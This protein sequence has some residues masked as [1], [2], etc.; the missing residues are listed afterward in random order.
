MDQ[1]SVD[2]IT[3]NGSV[4]PVSPVSPVSPIGPIGP[5]VPT[6]PQSSFEPPSPPE[7]GVSIDNST[8]LASSSLQNRPI[9]PSHHD[10][11]KVSLLDVV[12]T[13][14]HQLRFYYTAL[15]CVTM[16]FFTYLGDTIKLSH[17]VGLIVSGVGILYLFQSNQKTEYA[18]Y[19]K[20]EMELRTIDPE[21]KYPFLYTDVNMVDLLYHIQ[22]FSI[23]TPRNYQN[24]L[25][26][27]NDFLHLRADFDTRALARPSQNYETAEALGT[28]CIECMESIL[29]SLPPID[30]FM[31]KH[32]KAMARIQVLVLRHLDVMLKIADE[33]PVDIYKKY[34][35]RPDEPRRFDRDD[36][37][38]FSL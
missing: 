11:S 12:E 27:C 23:Y 21:N 31:L 34:L 14:N 19:E 22:D 25:N 33:E 9:H 35:D 13:P 20:M 16:A 2:P 5:I 37:F 10:F 32:K 3:V 17:I 38:K 29:Y 24:L 6:G 7:L 18:F 1:K 30:L 8:L 26:V 4:G 15:I 28:K 36:F